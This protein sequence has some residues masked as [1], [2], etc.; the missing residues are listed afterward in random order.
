MTQGAMDCMT[1]TRD[2]TLGRI[3]K[4]RRLDLERL[5]ARMGEAEDRKSTR[6][7]SSH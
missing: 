2:R 6:L 7:N 4:L 1:V 3:L 5:Q